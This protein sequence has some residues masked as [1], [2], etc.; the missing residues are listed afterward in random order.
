ML[1]GKSKKQPKVVPLRSASVQKNTVT[2]VTTLHWK[3][4]I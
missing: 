1:T 3:T 4:G 2:Y